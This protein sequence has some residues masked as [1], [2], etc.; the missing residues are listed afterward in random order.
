MFRQDCPR[1]QLYRYAVQLYFSH[2]VRISPE[3]PEDN[4][5]CLFYSWQTVLFQHVVWARRPA[6]II[7]CHV[8]GVSLPLLSLLL[9]LH[10]KSLEPSNSYFD[11]VFC[12]NSFA[13]DDLK[14]VAQRLEA[15]VKSMDVLKDM[16]EA[17]D[18]AATLRELQE[19]LETLLKPKLLEVSGLFPSLFLS[20]YVARALRC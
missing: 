13:Q 2:A 3:V 5:P 4:M 8:L 6:I 10:I 14:G 1:S 9:F 11:F 7:P 17:E 16:P 15:M 20:R 12:W 18:R 19:R